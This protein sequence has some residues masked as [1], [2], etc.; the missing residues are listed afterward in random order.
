MNFQT[1]NDLDYKKA[2]LIVLNSYDGVCP[3]C[4]NCIHIR[5]GYLDC[6]LDYPENMPFGCLDFDTEK[7][8]KEWSKEYDRFDTKCT[9]EN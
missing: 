1:Q 6:N 3:Y 7:F 9:K 8:L 5:G 2:F 4:K